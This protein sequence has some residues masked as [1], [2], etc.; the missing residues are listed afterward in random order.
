[1]EAKF[2]QITTK[3]NLIYKVKNKD[4]IQSICRM[5]KVD[6][7]SLKAL[8]KIVD[9]QEND[10]ILLPKPYEHIYV[11]KPLDTYEKIADELG[12]SEEKIIQVTKGKKMFIGQT[13]VF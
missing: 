9:V 5:F 2:M 11:V 6:A 12:V 3:S 10:V 1:M 13:I 4:T 8:N 7:N